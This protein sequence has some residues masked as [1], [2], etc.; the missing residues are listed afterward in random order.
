L[1]LN[2]RYCWVDVWSLERRINQTLARV[3]ESDGRTEPKDLAAATDALLRAYRG[4]FLGQDPEPWAIRTRDRLRDRYLRCLEE[5]GARPETLG[6]RETAR[7]CYERGLE[8]APASERCSRGLLR[9]RDQ[10]G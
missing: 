1:S 4:R 3:R 2:P 7:A 10:I 6:H 9:C 8:V 5:V